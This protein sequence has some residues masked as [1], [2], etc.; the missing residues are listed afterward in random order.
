MF[1]FLGFL[2]P[3]FL[4]PTRTDLELLQ[5][6]KTHYLLCNRKQFLCCF[7]RET[8]DGSPK[9]K[10]RILSI[11]NTHLD[12]EAVVEGLYNLH[13]WKRIGFFETRIKF[14]DEL[15]ADAKEAK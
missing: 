3:W 5:D 8:F 14:L 1:K 6:L 11:I 13:G 4:F 10:L 15:I 9:E 12:G 2:V 7:T